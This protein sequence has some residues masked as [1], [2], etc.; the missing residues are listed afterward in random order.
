MLSEMNGWANK[1]CINVHSGPK[2]NAVN[3]NGW[4]EG[5]HTNTNV[6]AERMLSEMKRWADKG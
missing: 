4:A 5:I 3:R 1:R 6:L 2:H